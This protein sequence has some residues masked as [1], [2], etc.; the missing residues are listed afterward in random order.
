MDILIKQAISAALCHSWDE[1]VK[2]NL[3]ILSDRENDIDSLNRLANA[4]IQ[5]NKIEAAK[6]I[7]KKILILDKYNA[8]AIKNLDKISSL[9]KRTKLNSNMKISPSLS[10]S[11]FIEEPGKTKTVSLIHVAPA[12]VLSILNIG[13]KV[14]LFPKKHSIDVRTENKIHLG[15]LPDDIAFRLLRFIKGGNTFEVY[16]KNV[17]KKCLM[18]FIKEASRGKKFFNQPTFISNPHEDKHK[19][20]DIK[21]KNSYTDDDEQELK[22]DAQDE[23]SEE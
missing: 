2:L 15:A 16:V 21:V 19:S 22:K 14:A 11:L 1:A 7:Y 3:E 17:S 12:S 9:N 8:I 20:K 13:D 23:E 10:P 5:S 6:K 4:Y 18:V